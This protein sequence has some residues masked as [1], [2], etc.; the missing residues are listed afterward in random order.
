MKTLFAILTLALVSFNAIG[1]ALI[2]PTPKGKEL[3]QQATVAQMRAVLGVGTNGLDLDAAEAAISPQAAIL[4]SDELRFTDGA[5][6]KSLTYETLRKQLNPKVYNVRQYGALGDGS[7]LDTTAI[8]TCIDL[9][10]TNNGT[11]FFPPG[12]YLISTNTLHSPYVTPVGL[13]VHGT[14]VCLQGAGRGAAVIKMD[15]AIA[16]DTVST[17][18]I[19]YATNVSVSDLG[20]DGSWV[21]RGEFVSGAENEGIHVYDNWADVSLSRLNIRNGPEDGIDAHKGYGY[22]SIDDVFVEG[23]GAVGISASANTPPVCYIQINNATVKNCAFGNP[24]PDNAGVSLYGYVVVNGMMSVSNNINLR[25]TSTLKPTVLNGCFFEAGSGITNVLHE[26]G[27]AQFIGCE[28]QGDDVSQ[29][30]VVI[31]KQAAAS[32]G[33]RTTFTGCKFT[34]RYG[35]YAPLAHQLNVIGCY[36][37]NPLDCITLVTNDTFVISGNYMNS[38]ASG[39]GVRF[40]GY[41]TAGI[42]SDNLITTAAATAIGG[43]SGADNLLISGNKITSGASASIRFDTTGGKGGNHFIKDNYAT[44]DLYLSESNCVVSGNRFPTVTLFG[45]S[46][47]DN[48]FTDNVFGPI[49]E[50]AGGNVALNYWRDNIG[51][52]GFPLDTDW[53][54]RIEAIDEFLFVNVEDGEVGSLGWKLQASTVRGG[55]DTDAQHIGTV[56]LVTTAASSDVAAIWSGINALS[57]AGTFDLN[58]QEPME[59]TCKFK[60]PDTNGVFVRLGFLAPFVGSGLSTNEY[61]GVFLRHR[62]STDGENFYF[63]SRAGGGGPETASASSVAANQEWHTLKMRRVVDNEFLM[64]LDGETEV[65]LTSNLPGAFT[66]PFLSVGIET[67]ANRSLRLDA[68]KLSWEKLDR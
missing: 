8:Q 60:I 65:A 51:L 40:S 4:D 31:D 24:L 23:C 61:Q 43:A 47:K 50:T 36:F 42:I 3:I 33:G 39:R 63:V 64:S 59:L 7:T 22:L 20:I 11:V 52:D 34:G 41:S 62:T 9:A 1:Q 12:I 29:Y 15:P 30:N 17:I 26:T 13:W 49:T 53:S 5:N 37:N 19:R 27:H 54:T 25:L 57:G 16:E 2:R 6:S 44:G 35:I 28:F 18:M 55:Q 67:N 10:A 46:A 21:E 56:D 58:G 48:F 45:T 14:N 66:G 68:V 32:T 38:S